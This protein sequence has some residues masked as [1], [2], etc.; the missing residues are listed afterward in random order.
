M[1]S[2]ADFIA[3]GPSYTVLLNGMPGD[4]KTFSAMT[5]PKVYFIGCDPSGLDILYQRGNEALLENLVHYEYLHNE[6]EKDLKQV[7]AERA[8]ADD[9]SSVY[10]C[11]AH[12][13]ELAKKGEVNSLVFDNFNFYVDMRWQYINE[14]EVKKSDRTG[15]LDTQAMY[16]DLGLH[17]NRF[18]AADLLTMATRQNLNVIV[19][20]HIKRETPEAVEG[21]KTRAGKVNK[22]TDI[23]P[24]I[25]GSFRQR[26]EGLVGASLYLERKG[27]KDKEGKSIVTYKAYTQKSFGL[28]TTLPAKNRYGLANPLDLTNKSLY[29]LLKAAT[30]NQAKANKE[31]K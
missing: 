20:S 17:L 28:D 3:K 14:Y 30:N 19:T 2:K 5:F 4:G 9:R 23:A 22:E 8:G 27:G 31:T 10:G 25:E 6:S 26:I 16:R 13:K 21:T 1:P 11:L 7:F 18:F 29:E 24:M 15:V 12:V